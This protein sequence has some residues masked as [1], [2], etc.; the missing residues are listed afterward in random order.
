VSPIDFDHDPWFVSSEIGDKLADHLLAAELHPFE[1][2]GAQASH[3]R[4]SGS[5][6]ALRFSRANG[7]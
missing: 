6:I 3:I 4:V 1:P 7:L 2:V 5:V